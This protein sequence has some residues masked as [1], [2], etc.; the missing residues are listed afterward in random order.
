MGRP[1]AVKLDLRRWRYGRR[2]HTIRARHGEL[3]A[4]DGSR[5]RSVLTRSAA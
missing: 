3:R 1:C 5:V 2:T 4:P